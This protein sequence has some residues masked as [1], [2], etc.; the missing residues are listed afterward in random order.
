MQTYLAALIYT[1]DHTSFEVLFEEHT[2]ESVQINQT[3]ATVP[4]PGKNLGHT[5]FIERITLAVS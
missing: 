4:N 2:D 5:S 3:S 1:P